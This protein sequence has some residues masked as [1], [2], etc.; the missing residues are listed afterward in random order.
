MQCIEIL[1][2]LIAFPTISKDSN[3]N[4]F[5]FVKEYLSEHGIISTRVRNK[6]NS[7]SNLYA[8]IEPIEK[9]GIILSK[10]SD[11][12]PVEGQTWNTNPF[13]LTEKGSQLYSRG[14]IDMKTSATIALTFVEEMKKIKTQ[15]TSRFPTT[16][17]S[18][19]SALQ[20]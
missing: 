15:F 10:N 18:I 3:L 20:K 12:V 6:N 19:V 5:D 7:K 14:T 16:R 9:S 13:V 4:L 1:E 17:K 11:I 2:K 8:T